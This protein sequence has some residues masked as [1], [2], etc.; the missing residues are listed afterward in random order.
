M[1]AIALTNFRKH[2][3]DVV[4]ETIETREPVHVTR[5]AGEGFVVVPENEWSAIMETMHVTSTSKNVS[6]LK[7]AHNQ[8]E[9][10]IARRNAT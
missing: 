1:T 10:E 2:L 5:S 6:R 7:S 8:I 4:Q 9:A 3:S